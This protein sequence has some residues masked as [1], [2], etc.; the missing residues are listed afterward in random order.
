MQFSG[1]SPHARPSGVAGCSVTRSARPGV[2]SAKASTT[3]TTR[4]VQSTTSRWRL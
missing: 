1:A 2:S 4:S 3:T